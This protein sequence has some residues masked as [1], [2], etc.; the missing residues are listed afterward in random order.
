MHYQDVRAEGW[1]PVQHHDQGVE[2]PLRSSMGMVRLGAPGELEDEPDLLLSGEALGGTFV[3]ERQDGARDYVDTGWWSP[4]PLVN[5]GGSGGWAVARKRSWVED[6]RLEQL[7]P[8]KPA[9]APGVFPKGHTAH[10]GRGSDED[11]QEDLLHPDFWGL[12]A[13]ARGG[14]PAAGTTVFD[15]APSGEPDPVKAQRMQSLVTILDLGQQGACGDVGTVV[16]L[17]LG[18]SKLDNL[19]GHGW[20]VNWQASEAAVSNDRTHDGPFSTGDGWCQHARKPIADGL[21]AGPLHLSERACWLGRNHDGPMWFDQREWEK[22]GEGTLWVNTWMRWDPE[23]QVP[24]TCFSRPSGAW[25]WET[26]VMVGVIPEPRRPLPEGGGIP[27]PEDEDG[28]EGGGGGQ[29]LTPERPRTGD[30][31]RPR[32]PL[33]DPETGIPLPEDEEEGQGFQPVPDGEPPGRPRTGGSVLEFLE[34]GGNGFV[35]VPPGSIVD[36]LDDV[37][38]AAAPSFGG[39]PESAAAASVLGFLDD[40]A[41]IMGPVFGSLPYGHDGQG[42]TPVHGTKGTYKEAHATSTAKLA[43]PGLMIRGYPTT[44]GELDPSG[45]QVA[46]ADATELVAKSPFVGQLVGLLDG[47]G[48]LDGA[49]QFELGVAAEW[50]KANGVVAFLPACLTA[51]DLQQGDAELADGADMGT[52][53][54][55]TGLSRL[56]FGT[57]GSLLSGAYQEGHNLGGVGSGI[58]WRLTDSGGTQ[59]QFPRLYLGGDN[60]AVL[61]AIHGTGLLGTTAAPSGSWGA[62]GV[63]GMAWCE[64]V[65]GT[66]GLPRWED[67]FA[68]ASYQ[69]V[70]ALSSALDEG[71]LLA[72]D[73]S[74]LRFTSLAAE[75]AGKL[76]VSQGASTRPAYQWIDDFTAESSPDSAAD[77]VLI[78]DDSAGAHRKVLLE[79]LPANSHD[80]LSASHEDTTAAAVQRGDLITGQGETPAWARLAA[81]SEGTY[82]R[83]GGDEPAWSGLDVD[84]ASAGTLAVARGGT[85][86]GSYTLGDMLYADATPTLAKLAGNTTA[87]RKFLRQVGNGTISAAPAW[88]T[89]QAADVPQ[90]DHGGLAGLGDDDHTIYLLA[91]GTRGLSADWDAGSHQIRAE[92]FQSDVA[93]GT[94][95]LVVASTTAVANLNADLLDGQE[96]SHYLDLGNATG[97]LDLARFGTQAANRVLAGPDSGAAANPTFR[98]LVADDIPDLSGTYAL[99]GH[100]HDADYQPLDAGL[101]AIAALAVTDGNIIVGDG[102]AW[103]AESGATART[104]LGLGAANSPSFAGLTLTSAAGIA[105][106][107]LENASGALRIAAA[108]A[109]TGL[110]GGGGS[111]LSVDI[112]GLSAD[113]SPDGAADY[114]M[115]HD[116]SAGTLKKVLLDDLPGGGGASGLPTGHLTGLLYRYLSG[117][118]LEVSPGACRDRQD[119][120]DMELDAF[121]TADITTSATGTDGSARTIAAVGGLDIKVLSGT[122]AATGSS[123]VITGTGTSFLTAF[124]PGGT[125]RTL[126]GSCGLSGNTVTGI[127]TRFLDELCVNDLVGYSSGGSAGFAAVAAIASD[128]SFTIDTSYTMPW[129]GGEGPLEV[130]E[131]PTLEI[132]DGSTAE[133]SR[134]L[135]IESDTALKVLVNPSFHDASTLRAG[136]RPLAASWWVSVW[137]VSG[138]TGTGVLLSG[139]RTALLAPPTGYDTSERRTGWIRDHSSGSAPAFRAYYQSG[140]AGGLRQTLVEEPAS[141]V[142]ALSAGTATSF[143]AVDLSAYCPPGTTA[144]YMLLQ[145]TSASSSTIVRAR[146]RGSSTTGRPFAALAAGNEGIWGLVPVDGKGSRQVDYARGGAHSGTY[147]DVSGWQ[148]NDLDAIHGDWEGL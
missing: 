147:I 43:A 101:T 128:T 64:S 116:G 15:L 55:P 84:D 130:I 142:R 143:T 94:A 39:T 45:S 108:A 61:G 110:T 93:T 120:A 67:L 114:V 34:E 11:A 21:T 73:S 2:L 95:P 30:P 54:F 139:Q 53:M 107:G 129:G 125:P 51:Y 37:E 133:T 102:A 81:G 1:W 92:T 80:L 71:D 32:V 20:W 41:S 65:A 122:G 144:V 132:D 4:A 50:P 96:G 141:A 74:E 123:Q 68:S 124:A 85:G 10:L 35:P 99:D 49:D 27:L 44:P 28:R 118:T 70:D 66:K 19:P 78:W 98:A 26:R 111:A 8:G 86:I 13:P 138:G 42:R 137:L 77:Y 36:L 57:F 87:T 16:A 7:G 103:V 117:D 131:Q 105:G 24:I 90:L 140:G 62:L 3:R 72:Y 69:I 82:L 115:T 134:V 135:G 22:P 38:T 33:D 46:D 88:D 112:N 6:D 17:Q 106:A 25:K 59:R 52:M 91:A 9:W 23:A 136:A 89:L 5:Q 126:T 121:A 12:Y 48:S 47:D 127:G 119:A 56:A 148:D 146:N 18:K 63:G 29:P 40:T 31:E 100:D 113:A 97:T 76:F 58:L 104:S 60:K 75:S 14:A 83:M 79:D 145:N 109:G